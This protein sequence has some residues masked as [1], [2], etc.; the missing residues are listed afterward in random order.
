MTDLDEGFDEAGVE[1]GVEKAEEV[2]LVCGNCGYEFPLSQLP[3]DRLTLVKSTL[4][5]Y[6][7]SCNH[8]NFIKKRELG[9][10]LYNELRAN[11][12]LRIEA[13]KKKKE[14]EREV[15]LPMGP[16]KEERVYKTA[17]VKDIIY[18]VATS[19]WLGLNEAQIK[20]LMDIVDD[21]GGFLSPSDFE[22]ILSS[23]DRVS[24]EK[25]KIARER[26]EMK[27]QREWEN[28]PMYVVESL[29]ISP[30]DRYR[31]RGEPPQSGMTAEELGRA[32][33]EAISEVLSNSRPRVRDSYAEYVGPAL[34]K[35]LMNIAESAGIVNR[36]INRVILTAMEEQ[37][38]RNP[39]VIGDIRNYLPAIFKRGEEGEEAK[40]EWTEKA[41]GEEARKY[42]QEYE[43]WEEATTAEVRKRKEKRQESIFADLDKYFD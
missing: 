39:Y 14:N 33:K 24:K 19:S 42:E 15:E 7:P 10:G 1:E 28:L 41:S 34:E 8:K 16:H 23:F 9:E 5:F 31:Q 18:E 37:V 29:N 32:L 6:C 12:R 26:Y 4:A 21:Y 13:E 43:L 11:V 38:K 2:R 25:A 27:L 36:F 40:E 17:S 22:R 20:E 3:D 35:A 30:P